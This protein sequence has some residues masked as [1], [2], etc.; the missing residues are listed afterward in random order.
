MLATGVPEKDTFS[1]VTCGIW[2]GRDGKVGE[3]VASCGTGIGRDGKT[4][5]AVA[6]C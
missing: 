3:A 2:I 4:G 6:S 5:G 1:A